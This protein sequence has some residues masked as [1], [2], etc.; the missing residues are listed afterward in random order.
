MGI[1]AG[2]IAKNTGFFIS[3]LIGTIILFTLM[4]KGNDIISHMFGMET[5]TE[6]INKYE[7]EKKQV[8]VLKDLNVGNVEALREI[9]KAQSSKEQIV[10]DYHAAEKQV[11]KS[12]NQIREESKRYLYSLAPPNENDLTG[13]LSSNNETIEP[14]KV[15][16]TV[17]TKQDTPKIKSKSNHPRVFTTTHKVYP[18]KKIQTPE[19]DKKIAKIVITSIHAAY[20]LAIS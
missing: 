19:N 1:L 4:V 12:F 2:L 17:K 7:V 15:I 11:Q 3:L 9:E 16:Q 10:A 20:N 18:K 8:E 5:K 6:L 14:N 13:L